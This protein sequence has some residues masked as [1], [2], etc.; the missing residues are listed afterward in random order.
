ML[1]TTHTERGERTPEKKTRQK[2]ETKKGKKIFCGIGRGFSL[3]P[4][5]LQ[6]A[7]HR[8]M[9]KKILGD[10]CKTRDKIEDENTQHAK[11]RQGKSYFT[12]KKKTHASGQ[13]YFEAQFFFA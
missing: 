3:P 13:I 12:G 9:T 1:G 6:Q 11:R 5:S 2:R 4:S 7:E 10:E 8:N